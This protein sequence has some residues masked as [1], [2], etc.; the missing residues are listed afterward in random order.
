MDLFIVH[1]RTDLFFEFLEDE[2]QE[3]KIGIPFL[4]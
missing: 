3:E 4:S 2:A 1:S